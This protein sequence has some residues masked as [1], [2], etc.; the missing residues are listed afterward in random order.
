MIFGLCGGLARYFNVDSTLVRIIF[1]LLTMPGGAGIL[2]YV[3]LSLITPLEPGTE[4]N[5]KEEVK[6]FAKK[7]KKEAKVVV[8]EIKREKKRGGFRVILGAIIAAVGV[9]F[10]VQQLFP[11]F[12]MGMFFWPVVAVVFGIYLVVKDN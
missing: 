5:P 9:G 7:V 12:H 8:A 10:I 1:V 3:I 6:E 11:F 2:A 4:T